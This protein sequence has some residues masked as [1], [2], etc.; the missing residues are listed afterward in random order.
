[1]MNFKNI[2]KCI[3]CISLLTIVPIQEAD[4]QAGRVARSAIA[5]SSKLF[6]KKAAKKTAKEASEEIVEQGTK[7]LSKEIVQRTVTKNAANSILNPA[8]KVSKDLLE[9]VAATNIKKSL[10][11]KAG[12]EISESALRSVSQEFSQ[13]I[14]KAAT[15]ETQELFTRKLG[16]EAS[17]ELGERSAKKAMKDGAFDTQKSLG[18][19]LKDIYHKLSI[20]LLQKI[21][22]SKLNKELLEIYAKGPI[23]LSEK[24]MAE[25]LANPK[26]FRSY[27][28]AKIGKKDVIEFLIRLKMDNPKQVKQ[29]LNHPE[30]LSYIKKSIRG[31]KGAHEWLMVKNIEDFLFNPK[32]GKNGDLLAIALCKLT[33]KTDNVIF[34]AGGKHGGLNSTR[35]H[36]GLS[37]VIDKSTSIEELFVNIRRY[38]KKNLTTDGYNEFLK[39]FESIFEAA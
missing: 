28:K 33:Q 1:M 35:F 21:Q 16:T 7:A 19:K 31:N 6:G 38:A 22:K 9:E 29:I 20:E 12:K 3:L 18:E 37:K 10:I 15:R 11:R 5:K 4:A 8:T 26:Y 36:N 14:G 23:R 17:R 39:I 24:E 30:L 32:W 27:M 25:L 2:G 34:K 13:Q